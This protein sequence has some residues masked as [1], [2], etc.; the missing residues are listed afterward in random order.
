MVNVD[1]QT[2][3][4]VL[5]LSEMWDSVRKLIEAKANPNIMFSGASS[6]PWINTCSRDKASCSGNRK[7]DEVRVA[8]VLQ[9]AVRASLGNLVGF[10][11]A[12]GADPNLGGE[13][14]IGSAGKCHLERRC[15]TGDS[16]I[17][18]GLLGA[19]ELG[20]EA[21]P[22]AKL[23]LDNGADPNVRGALSLPVSTV[24]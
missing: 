21:F 15:A 17:G 19:C 16:D 13:L 7:G 2:A 22:I 9:A 5:A 10:L 4:E 11:L 8:T 23:L 6:I 3:L 18:T 24:R 12:N 20:K 14:V 1:G